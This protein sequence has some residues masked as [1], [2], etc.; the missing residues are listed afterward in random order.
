M[1]TVDVQRFQGMLD[2]DDDVIETWVT[3]A[4]LHLGYDQAEISIVLVDD[5]Y[6]Q[7]LNKKYLGRD[8][9][10]NVI[11][12][13]QQEGMGPQ[14]DHLGDVVVSV[15]R[16][17]AEAMAASIGDMDRVLE[18]LIHGICHLAGY[19][20]EGV[21]AEDAKDMFRKEKEILEKIKDID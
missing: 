12:F 8:R 15:E 2:I 4:L 6:I 3:D 16:A 19:D 20:H 13:S 7:R 18:L 17:R 11:A 21:S 14:N 10:T 9:P 1:I 5:K